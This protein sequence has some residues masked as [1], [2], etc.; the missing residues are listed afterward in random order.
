MQNPLRRYFRANPSDTPNALSKR[1]KLSPQTVNNIL[2]V[3]KM[4]VTTRTMEKLCRA[5]MERVDP[6]TM[7]ELV[8]WNQALSEFTLGRGE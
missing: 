4:Q 2:H 6:L 8:R 3:H 5:T 1:A 7:D